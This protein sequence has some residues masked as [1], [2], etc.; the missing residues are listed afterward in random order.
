MS[1]S[2][3]YVN[4]ATL[5]HINELAARV[6]AQSG[7][8]GDRFHLGKLILQSLKDDPD[9]VMQIDGATGESVTFQQGL[10][11]SVR[12]AIA[13]RNMGLRVG[14]VIVLMSPNYSDLAAVFYAAL[15]L[16]V[17]L[18]PVDMRRSVLELQRIF[19]VNKPKIVFCK[20][21]KTRQATEA[22]TA[23]GQKPLIVTFDQGE[24]FMIYQDFI[25]KYSDNSPSEDFR[26]HDFNTEDTISMFLTTSGTTGLPKSIACSHKNYAV[27][28][29]YL[30]SRF[31]NFPT[32][33]RLAMVCSN[34]Q[35]TTAVMNYLTSPIMRFTRL[36][37]SQPLTVEHAY[38]LINTYKPTFC[39]L[40]PSL[41]RSWINPATR[42]KCNF[43]FEVIYV[44]G[45]H[46]YQELLDDAKKAMPE[47][48]ICNI[49][50]MS[51]LCGNA[52][53]CRYPS[54][55]SCGQPIGCHQYRL[56]DV[57][58][59]KEI[60]EPNVK[61]ELWVK[62]PALI[63]GYHN[64]PE[65]TKGAFTADKWFKTG[66]LFYRDE[67]WNFFFM[68]RLKLILKYKNHKI[69]PAELE[70]VILKHP[71]VQDVVV[72]GMQDLDSW[73]LPVAFVI[74]KPDSNVTAQDLKDMVKSSLS[75]GKQLRGGVVFLDSFPLTA[76]S[77]VHRMK[78][79]DM[80]ITMHRE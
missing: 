62:G 6:V 80:A 58:T 28:V 51:E 20:N 33:T 26:P 78:L 52:F 45:S 29:P 9:F 12:C 71:G 37:T 42:D 43:S 61:G 36:H 5:L 63:K 60:I 40:S 68:D 30:W 74:R 44:G 54:L 11:R 38:H 8:P 39:L 75:D 67:H 76:T 56:V 13:L 1:K 32:P 34:V 14:D 57:E 70:S 64:N 69:S 55:G 19:Q 77:K 18:A 48:E 72:V 10:E 31:T 2:P 23:A 50:G 73:D 35:W 59:Q 24:Q 66:D 3:R 47:T 41:L 17:V 15:Y 49:Y 21:D 7:I 4:D 65:A 27:V 16:G 46:V 22:L 25:K 79:Q 53:H